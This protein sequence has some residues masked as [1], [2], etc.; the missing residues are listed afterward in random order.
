MNHTKMIGFTVTT[1][2]IFAWVVVG[3]CAGAIQG[4]AG[5]KMTI[6]DTL[7]DEGQRTTIAFSGLAFLSGDACSDTFLPPGKVADYAGFQYL[8]DNDATGMGHNTDFVTRAAD[9]VISILN[10]TQLANYVALGNTESA[11][12]TRYAYMRFPLMK[13]FRQNLEGTIPTGS[14]GLNYSAVTEYSAQLYDI[15][16]SITLGRAKTYSA[17]INSLNATQ[18][19]Y[20][21]KM[22]SGGMATWPV[23]DVSEKLKQLGQGNSVAM[24]TYASEMFSWYAGSVEADTYFCPERIATYFGS[25][26]MKD[27]PAMG[28]P[29]YSIS[30]TLTHDSGEAF[31]ALLNSS[32]SEKITGLVALQKADLYEIVSVRQAISTALRQGLTGATIDENLV[33]T[34]SARYGRLEGGISYNYATRFADVGKTSTPEQKKKMVE[35]RNLSQYTCDGAYLYSEPIS[36]PPNI[37][38]DFL[39]TSGGGISPSISG[40]TPDFGQNTSNVSVTI[41]GSNFRDGAVVKLVKGTVART[42]IVQSNSGSRITC[43]LPLS[44]VSAGVYDLTITNGDGTYGTKSGAFTVTSVIPSN[45]TIKSD[46]GVDG[47][48]LPKEYTCDGAGYSPALSWSQ[49]PAGTKEFALML[50]TLPV[51]GST[52]WNWVLYRIPATASGLVKNSTGVGINGMNSHN[53][54]AYA[55]PCAQGPGAKVYTFTIYALSASPILPESASLVTGPVLT[56]A[57]SSITL[58]SASINM[59]NSRNDNTTPTITGITPN[60]GNNTGNITISIGGTNFRTGAIV[61]ITSGKSIKAGVV[62]QSTGTQIICILPLSGVQ[63]GLYNLTVTNTDGTLVTKSNAF[64]VIAAGPNPIINAITPNSGFATQNTLVTIS[65]TNFRPGATVE[66]NKGITVKS[67]TV[68]SCAL[69]KIVCTLPTKGLPDGLWSVKVRNADGTTATKPGGFTIKNMKST[70]GNEPGAVSGIVLGTSVTAPSG[71]VPSSGGL[72]SGGGIVPVI[73]P[74]IKPGSPVL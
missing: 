39:F 68:T 73:A 19:A 17:V 27:R 32:Q 40:I 10:A 60:F 34:L 33:R 16:A 35:L 41:T 9:N 67:A 54:L 26:Y 52:K 7:S 23:V 42:G 29:N 43:V 44:G 51:D 14:S 3:M 74:G 25:F 64:T 13:A 4:A 46:A 66:M 28:N 24:R 63:G 37:S 30:T 5:Q 31:L 62:Q 8:R 56:Q 50:T 59:S 6:E 12:S 55:P 22:K 45:F 58:G 49:V 53:I 18:R 48:I 2:C 61:K 11:L 20:L 57:I 69:T 15:D 47:G 70:Q 72:V 71:G 21:D 1:L 36:M 65:G 38:T